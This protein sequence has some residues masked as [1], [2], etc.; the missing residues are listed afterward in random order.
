MR[1]SESEKKGVGYSER[2]GGDGGRR[3][4]EVE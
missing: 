4:G 3:G 1:V 2:E